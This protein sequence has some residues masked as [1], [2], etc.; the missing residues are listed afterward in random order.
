[1]VVSVYICAIVGNLISV[2]LDS[3]C[4]RKKGIA[5][6]SANHIVHSTKF[7]KSLLVCVCALFYHLKMSLGLH[8]D[9]EIDIKL[10]HYSSVVITINYWLNHY[11]W[12][13]AITASSSVSWSPMVTQT[14]ANIRYLRVR[15]R[16]SFAKFDPSQVLQ[17]L[18]KICNTLHRRY[19][20]V[21]FSMTASTNNNV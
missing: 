7:S 3:N 8:D 20:S 9:M 17:C 1:M 11:Q 15:N 18:W 2:K 6:L 13:D 14:L 10:H 4:H 19:L 21:T 16:R 12:T 5:E